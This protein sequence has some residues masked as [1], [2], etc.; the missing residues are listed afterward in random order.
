MILDNTFKGAG[1]PG[2]LS[3][4]HHHHTELPLDGTSLTLTVGLTDVGDQDSNYNNTV[5]LKN[6][7]MFFP[8]KFTIPQARD[9]MPFLKGNSEE[10]ASS[11]KVSSA[12]RVNN[13]KEG[14]HLSLALLHLPPSSCSA[15][16]SWKT[17]KSLR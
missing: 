10:S 12:Q 7:K 8:P 4:E 17:L 5:A 1:Q 2:I 13:Y 11:Q 9:Q 15:Q 14:L 16:D 6:K 3:W